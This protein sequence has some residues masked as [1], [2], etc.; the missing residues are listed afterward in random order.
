MPKKKPADEATSEI[1]TPVTRENF[2]TEYPTHKPTETINL[3]SKNGSRVT[4]DKQLADL[5]L[6]GGYTL[7]E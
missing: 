4:V 1:T 3:I 5:L 2:T 6:A 7:A